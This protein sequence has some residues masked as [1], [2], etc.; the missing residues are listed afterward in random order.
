MSLETT[1]A[2]RCW[3][4]R[5]SAASTRSTSLSLYSVMICAPRQEGF[6]SQA[7][8]STGSSRRTSTTSV[9]TVFAVTVLTALSAATA[10]GSRP[11]LIA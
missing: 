11:G 10:A 8:R 4:M 3:V 1:A 6:S 5:S 9:A 2:V 7:R